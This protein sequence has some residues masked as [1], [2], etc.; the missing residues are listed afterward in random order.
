MLTFHS[1]ERYLKGNAFQICSD[2]QREG[3]KTLAARYARQMGGEKVICVEKAGFILGF[4]DSGEATVA[5]TAILG[6]DWK[7][8]NTLRCHYL[9]YVENIYPLVLNNRNFTKP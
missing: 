3:G 1:N 4:D 6:L 5:T 7:S 8:N 2:F 9:L